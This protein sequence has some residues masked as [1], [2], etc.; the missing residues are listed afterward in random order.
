MKDPI[1]DEVRKHRDKLAKKFHYDIKA[2]IADA[3]QRQYLESDK[4]VSFIKKR[5]KSA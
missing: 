2:I 3:Q 1:V 4:I 5:K